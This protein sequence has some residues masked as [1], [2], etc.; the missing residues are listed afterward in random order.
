MPRI[1]RGYSVGHAYHVLN[2]GNGGGTIF[3]TDSDCAA[4]PD[5][6]GVAKARHPVQISASA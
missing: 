5:L 1:P 3:H 2:R 6:L 4:F